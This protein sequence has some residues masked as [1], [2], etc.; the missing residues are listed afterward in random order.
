MVGTRNSKL[1]LTQT[2]LV[3]DDL[4]KAGVE[5]PFETKEI[6]TKGDR[7]LD[8]ALSQVGGSDIFTQEIEQAMYDK[9]IDFAVHSMKDLSATEP[10]GLTI[11]A[12]P[13]RED[14]RDAYIAKDNVALKD[15]P[16]GAVVGTSSLRRA[17]QMLAVRPD[18]Q[19]KWIRGAIDARIKKLHTEDYDAII[20]AAAGLNRLGLSEANITEYLPVDTFI[21]SVGQGALAIECR[22]DDTEL[23]EILAKINDQSALKTVQAERMFLDILQG[24][25]QFPIGAYAY[26]DNNEIILHAT[27]ISTDGKTVLQEFVRGADADQVASEAADKLIKRGAEDII[28]EVKEVLNQQ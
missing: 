3:I 26:L 7:V 17:A 9:E 14:P 15:L 23:L 1:A 18:L 2:N 20:L 24:N 12:I 8:V 11:A 21:P 25:D 16:A 28:N 27:V 19:T 5:N 4:K 10:D 22:S 13:E 6:V